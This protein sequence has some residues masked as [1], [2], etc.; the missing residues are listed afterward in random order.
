MRQ[1]PCKPDSTAHSGVTRYIG[2]LMASVGRLSLE[3]DATDEA[4]L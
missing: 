4:L 2:E 1:L 3:L